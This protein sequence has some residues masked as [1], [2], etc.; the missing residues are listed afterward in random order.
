MY[1]IPFNFTDCIQKNSVLIIQSNK[2][3]SKATVTAKESYLALVFN[4]MREIV[5]TCTRVRLQDLFRGKP[6]CQ[7][8][9]R[10]RRLR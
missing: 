7:D 8:V 1:T 4:L 6:R 5:M 9:E 2:I 10:G 3:G